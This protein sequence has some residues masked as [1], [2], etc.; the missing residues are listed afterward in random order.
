MS[1]ENNPNYFPKYTPN[2]LTKDLPDYLKDPANYQKIQVELLNTLAIS[3]SHSEMIDWSN[4]IKC[5]IKVREHADMMRKLGF[6]N[7]SQYLSW[8]KTMEYIINGFDNKF[9][10]FKKNESKRKKTNTGDGGKTD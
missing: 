9:K 4:C 2:P 5:Q 10:E 8:K 1:K 7:G 6:K 3:H